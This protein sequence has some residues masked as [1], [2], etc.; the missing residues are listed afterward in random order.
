MRSLTDTI[1]E[2]L[3]INSVKLPNE[4]PFPIDGSITDMAEFL[5]NYKF[6]E[7]LDSYDYESVNDIFPILNICKNKCYMTD[8]DTDH[9]I[10]ICD[11]TKE[12][13]SK[14]NP[15][16]FISYETKNYDLE[17]PHSIDNHLSKEECLKYLK[18]KFDIE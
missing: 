14:N 5:K 4:E 11:T 2:K 18:K 10:R 15:C 12:K 1:L 6:E 9:W 13:I 17:C 16:V 3:D 7:V 8:V